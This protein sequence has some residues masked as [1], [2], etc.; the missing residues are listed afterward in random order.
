M[1]HLEYFD[2]VGCRTNEKKLRNRK[3]VRKIFFVSVLVSLFFFKKDK[4]INDEEYY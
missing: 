2:Y 1:A 4:I 3:F